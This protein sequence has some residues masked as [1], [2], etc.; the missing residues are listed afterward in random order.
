MIWSFVYS[1]HYLV[2]S[3]SD[4]N[5]SAYYGDRQILLGHSGND[6]VMKRHYILYEKWDDHCPK[7]L[8][9][10]WLFQIYLKRFEWSNAR[11]DDLWQALSEVSINSKR[12]IIHAYTCTFIIRLVYGPISCIYLCADILHNWLIL[13]LFFQVEG[14]PNV[15]AIMD[16]WTRQMGFPVISVTLDNTDPNNPMVVAKQ[17]HCLADSTSIVNVPSEYGWART[18]RLMYKVKRSRNELL[19]TCAGFVLHYMVLIYMKGSLGRCLLFQLCY[20]VRQS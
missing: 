7:L 20:P 19:L 13:T 15:K 6:I 11:T 5:A 10:L 8:Y 2:G 18:N 14:A 16:T 9:R 4:P 1:I 17:Q 3:I 12:A